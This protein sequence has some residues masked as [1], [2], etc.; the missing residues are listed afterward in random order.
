MLV[1]AENAAKAAGKKMHS[2]TPYK[3]Q[4]VND[5]SDPRKA[6]AYSGSLT[7][8]GALKAIVEYVFNGSRYK[9]FVPS[10]NC[11]IVF[12]IENLKSPQPTAPASAIARGQGKV[13][14]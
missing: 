2:K 12:A 9:M 8:A 5:L 14:L 11:H 10:E 3:K 6:K 4:T 1:A 13:V 7:R